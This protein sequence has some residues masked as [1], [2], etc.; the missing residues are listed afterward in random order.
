MDRLWAPWRMTYID[1]MDDNVST[2]GCFLCAARDADDA[3][4]AASLR[5]ADAAHVYDQRTGKH[6]GHDA[7][8]TLPLDPTSATVLSLLPYAVTDLTVTGPNQVCFPALLP[9]YSKIT[10]PSCPTKIVSSRLLAEGTARLRLP[11]PGHP[12]F[13]PTASILPSL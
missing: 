8:I 11:H 2:G 3:K 7:S 5:L 1:G 13:L 12:L 9:R 4:V 6:Y 10:I